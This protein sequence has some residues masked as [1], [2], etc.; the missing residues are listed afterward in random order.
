MWLRHV[1]ECV[2]EFGHALGHCAPATALDDVEGIARDLAL[3]AVQ[4]QVEG[5]LE[6]L[7]NVRQDQ[8]RICRNVD[9]YVVS[10]QS[11]CA[12]RIVE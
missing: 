7:S 5:A 10:E 8:S 11:T 4:D 12:V 9:P 3:G 1:I 6:S 2:N